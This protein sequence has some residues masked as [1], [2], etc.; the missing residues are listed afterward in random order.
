MNK[1]KTYCNPLSIPDY[2]RGRYTFGQFKKP[3]EMGWLQ[4]ELCDFRE[5]ADPSVLWHEGKWYL[6]PSAGM[7]WVSED[8]VTWEHHRL[9]P[10]DCGYAP[11]VVKHQDRFLLTA[12]GAGLWEA[13]HPLGPWRECGPILDPEGQALPNWL[14]PMLF[15]D[16][17]GRLYLY[18]GIAA[19]GIFGAELDAK[20]PTRLIE[21]PRVLFAFDPEHEW[22]RGGDHNESHYTSFIEGPWMLK[23][24]GCYYLTYTGPGTEWKTYA[25]GAYRATSPMGPFVYQANNPFCV[26]REGLVQGAG[27]G[28]VVRG[29]SE[30]LWVF[31]TCRVCYEHMF[32]RRLGMDP[33]WIDA[34]GNLVVRTSEIPQLAPGAVTHP[35][36]GNDAGW[37]PVSYR[38]GAKA[39]SEAS[40]RPPIYAVDQS[41]LTWWQPA[42]DDA[43]PW[44]ELRL[45]PASRI[46]ALRLVWKDVGLDYDQGVSPGPFRWRLQLLPRG[47]N[48]EWVT[49]LDASDNA[50]DQLIEY[51]EIPATDAVC[52]RLEIVGW[53][54]GITPGLVDLTLF[55][56]AVPP[57][58]VA[59]P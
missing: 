54:E 34:E 12:C 22:E 47:E 55:G 42:Q 31:Y 18:W 56:V 27:H 51:R 19:P 46:H 38:R 21:P 17:D 7:A 23:V 40:G 10:Y 15:S 14:D 39:S 16:D 6:F 9:H 32:E 45:G 57:T 50:I 28:C 43:A 44:I 58:P 25:M 11:T 49:V 35:E 36:L 20:E 37:L 4:K 30:T 24:G 59:K 41:M 2:P 13:P 5:L 52:A 8:F 26:K 48:Q 1:P 29:P 33:A 3:T 53:P